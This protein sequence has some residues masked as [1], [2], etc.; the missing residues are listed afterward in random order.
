MDLIGAVVVVVVAAH[1]KTSSISITS[2]YSATA[3]A[4]THHSL[5]S[6]TP[7]RNTNK[8][9]LPFNGYHPAMQYIFDEISAGCITTDMGSRAINNN[10]ED[11]V[12]SFKLDEM[13]YLS[14]FSSPRT[15][16][17]KIV[18]RDRSQSSNG[19]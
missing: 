11:T 7:R 3:T 6:M 10:Y 12:R 15:S 17:W 16:I 2:D 18:A 4:V 8:N 5:D 14:T 19:M 9:M 13:E 1:A